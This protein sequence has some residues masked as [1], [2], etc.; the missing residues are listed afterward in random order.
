VAVLSG[1]KLDIANSSFV[2]NSAGD[3]GGAVMQLGGTTTLTI[4][5]MTG[6]Q[7]GCMLKCRDKLSQGESRRMSQRYETRPGT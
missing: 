4:C 5:Q 6:N 3:G 2:D 1:G 7:V